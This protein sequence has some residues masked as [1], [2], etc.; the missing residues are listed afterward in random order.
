MI[1]LSLQTQTQ[2]Q[3]KPSLFGK[4]LFVSG[5]NSADRGKA[6][7]IADGCII[8]EIR[9]FQCPKNGI[10]RMGRGEI[11]KD[12][13]HLWITLWIQPALCGGNGT[14]AGGGGTDGVVRERP[15]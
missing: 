5:A 8:M 6:L 9:I 12:T 4:V 2:T 10:P 14:E 15:M 11:D 1:S 3:K 13:D 7:V